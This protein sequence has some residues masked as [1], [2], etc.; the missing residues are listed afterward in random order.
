MPALSE[1]VATY[2]VFFAA[3]IGFCGAASPA[4][5][6]FAITHGDT[7]PTDGDGRRWRC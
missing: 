5:S 7:G 6:S 4:S 2:V 1:D 3:T